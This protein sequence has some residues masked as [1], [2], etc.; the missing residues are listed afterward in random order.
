MVELEALVNVKFKA[1]FKIKVRLVKMMMRREWKSLYTHI[2][3]CNMWELNPYN[4][5]LLSILI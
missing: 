3:T 2:T 1:R 5:Q 4:T